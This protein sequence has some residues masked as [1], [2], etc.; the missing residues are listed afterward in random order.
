MNS[1]S[2]FCGSS[3]GYDPVYREQAALLG[4]TLARRQYEIVYGGSKIGLMGALADASLQEGGRV[5]GVIPYFLNSKEIEHPSLTKTIKVQT[6]HE[7][8]TKMN[9]LSDAVIAMPGGFGTLEEFFEILTWAQLGLHKKPMGLFNI[10]GYF[11]PLMEML[12]NMKEKGFLKES[13]YQ[14][15]LISSS[16]DELLT[17][18]DNYVA[19]PSE[20]WIYN[21]DMT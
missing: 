4:K 16:I 19:I 18:M 6:M 1:I 21:K 9:E 13:N 3:T 10:N 15:V 17:K 2:V 20:K 11:D 5:T 12:R 7:R 8:K 14:M